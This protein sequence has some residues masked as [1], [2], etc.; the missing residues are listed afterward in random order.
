[1][2]G[3]VVWRTCRPGSL[4]LGQARRVELARALAPGPELL[5]LD[6]P[7]SGLDEEETEE[8]GHI[9]LSLRMELGATILLVEHDVAL[10][11]RV[12]DQTYVLDFGQLIAH[13]P[14]GQVL[15]DPAVVAAYLGVEEVVL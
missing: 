4:P 6:E 10:V 9:V 7:A 3:P 5:L 13:G 11:A 14:T 8:F 2:S 1:M 15:S 12:S